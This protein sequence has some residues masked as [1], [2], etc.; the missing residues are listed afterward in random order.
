M[1]R[2]S[3][4]L[5]Q[6]THNSLRARISALSRFKYYL[7]LKI[8]SLLKNGYPT[9]C[10]ISLCPRS[11]CPLVTLSPSLCP[12]VSLSPGQF[13]PRLLCPRSLCPRSLC[14]LVSLSPGHFVPRSLC[15]PVTLSPGHFV[16]WSRCPWSLLPLPGHVSHLHF[17]SLVSVHT[18]TN[19]T[20]WDLPH[21]LRKT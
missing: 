5:I 19:S 18:K 17:L 15:P 8:L 11:L 16:P 13:V 4:V 14:P 10:P 1:S 12:P 6:P 21:L 9:L 2:G 20:K 7:L 3:G